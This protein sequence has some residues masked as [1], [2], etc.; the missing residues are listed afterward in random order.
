MGRRWER[1]WE[2]VRS[3]WFWQVAQDSR[4]SQSPLALGD[5][6]WT[7]ELLK[8]LNIS[9][10]LLAYSSIFMGPSPH[11]T[12]SYNHV[13]V[14]NFPQ[15]TH[16]FFIN[17]LW[18][19]APSLGG[20][21]FMQKKATSGYLQQFPFSLGSAPRPSPDGSMFRW[22]DR[23]MMVIVMVIWIVIINDG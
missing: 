13:N 12:A 8:S 2:V 19:A 10:L 18:S 16:Q 6:L 9:H 11:S 20:L 3:N 21:C 5:F 14:H 17:Q 7:T 22:F 4:N 1:G 23:L 15:Q